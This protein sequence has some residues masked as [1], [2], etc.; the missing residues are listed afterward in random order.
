MGLG[1]TPKRVCMVEQSHR[2]VDTARLPGYSY[3]WGRSD[4]EVEC[5]VRVRVCV[6]LAVSTPPIV[7]EG[8]QSYVLLPCPS[9][10]VRAFE[11]RGVESWS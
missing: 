6:R 1:Y 7:V 5:V 2:R 11:V 4:L 9:R 10:F 8:G 3:S